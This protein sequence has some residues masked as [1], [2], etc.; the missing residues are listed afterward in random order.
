M[1][2]AE[3]AQGPRRERGQGKGGDDDASDNGTANGRLR[4]ACH[5]IECDGDQ[6]DAAIRAQQNAG[7]N[8]D[9]GGSPALVDPRFARVIRFSA[10]TAQSRARR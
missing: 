5:H 3:V 9:A 10:A 8:G 1:E 6:Q 4:A 2:G 7:G